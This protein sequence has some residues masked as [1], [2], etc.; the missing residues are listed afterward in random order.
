MKFSNRKLAVH[1][2]RLGGVVTRC[3]KVT[4]AGNTSPYCK[5]LPNCLSWCCFYRMMIWLMLCWLSSE[6]KR[7]SVHCR[8]RWVNPICFWQQGRSVFGCMRVCMWI[9][10]NTI[11]VQYGL[12]YLSYSCPLT[13][14]IPS[15]FCFHNS[16]FPFQLVFHLLDY[17]CQPIINCIHKVICCICH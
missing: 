16:F 11:K 1:S 15:C 9:N 17:C 7:L 5:P 14:T 2:Q 8:H 3:C 10:S 4:R 12:W 6:R 13:S